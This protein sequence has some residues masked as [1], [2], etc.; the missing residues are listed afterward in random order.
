MGQTYKLRGRV[1]AIS[2]PKSFA[3]GFTMQELLLDDESSPQWPQRIPVGFGGDRIA[4]LA[5]LGLGQ[6][7][8]VT[9]SIRGSEYNGRRYVNLRGWNVSTISAAPVQTVAPIGDPAPAA[10]PAAAAPSSSPQ[11]LEDLPF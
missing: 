8:E 6:E 2:A 10:A 7:V 11:G 3:S 5:T 1:A 9:F 4:Q